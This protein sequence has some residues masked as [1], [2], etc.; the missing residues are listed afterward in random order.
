MVTDTSG[1]M[2]A[3]DVAPDRLTAAKEAG[4]AL[5]DK[6]PRDFRLGLVGFGTTAELLVEPTTDK[7]RVRAGLEASPSA[8]RL[9]WATGSRSGWKLRA[10]G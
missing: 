1:S 10:P 5:A 4:R 3:K 9:R 7:L 8:A 2:F 6:L